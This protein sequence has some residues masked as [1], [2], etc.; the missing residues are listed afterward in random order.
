MSKRLIV[1][2][3][4]IGL[5]ASTAI[6]KSHV[7]T[8]NTRD[9]I[10]AYVKDAA[11][12]VAKSGPSCDTFKSS[13]WMKGDYYVFVDDPNTNKLVCHP[14]ASMV[15]KDNADIVDANGKKVGMDLMA[16][17]KK[18][19]GG[20]TNYVWP[21]PGTDKPVPKSTYSMRVKGPGGK[22]YVVGAGGY[23]LK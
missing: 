19:G 6:A 22:W 5:V 15:G 14:N 20:W 11:K 4:L 7:P 2:T 3:L 23:E 10:K 1:G 16:A 18:K 8:R 17:A 13:D 9:A 12:V 21:R